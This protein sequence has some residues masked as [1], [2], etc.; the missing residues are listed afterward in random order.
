[1]VWRLVHN[2]QETIWKTRSRSI[3]RSIVLKFGRR[4]EENHETPQIGYV[5]G[6][7]LEPWTTRI[8][9]RNVTN[10]TVARIKRRWHSDRWVHFSLRKTGMTENLTK[11]PDETLADFC[12]HV[13][14]I[15]NLR[16]FSVHTC[17]LEYQWEANGMD[18]VCKSWIHPQRTGRIYMTQVPLVCESWTRR[19]GVHLFYVIQRTM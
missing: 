2:E 10:S 7:R 6:L 18:T 15:G 3:V 17:S 13:W 5:S 1:M 14:Q 4:D 8:R 11:K 12:W 19:Y 9:S 16:V